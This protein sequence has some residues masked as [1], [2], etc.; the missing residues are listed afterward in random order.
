MHNG[1]I[2][3]FSELG[4]VKYAA[5][6]HLRTVIAMAFVQVRRIL[7]PGSAADS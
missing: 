6:L 4:R 1:L 3:S 5:I 7:E 2:C